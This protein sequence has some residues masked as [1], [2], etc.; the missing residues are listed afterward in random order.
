M[1]LCVIPARGGSKRIPRKNLKDFAGRPILWYSVK[2]ALE[3]AVF[4]RIVVSTDDDEI[5]AAGRRFGATVPFRR[6]IELSDDHVGTVPV[7]SHAISALK[8]QGERF[9]FVACIY[10]TAPLL[11]PETIRDGLTCLRSS[12]ADYAVT[13]TTFPFPIQRA[14]RINSDERLEMISSQFA[15]TRSQDLEETYHD[16]G[17]LY[18]GRTEA[19]EAERP[20]FVAGAAVPVYVPRLRVQ[21]I[22]TLED[23]KR[24]EAMFT[25]IASMGED[26]T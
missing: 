26:S 1:N 8:A 10:A 15:M 11:R 23:W 17:Q 14:V 18:W 9:D 20:I 3:A 6:P 22:D 2:A 12:D 13:V 19:F 25:A 4:D 5:A 7:I 24:A 16:A 21:D